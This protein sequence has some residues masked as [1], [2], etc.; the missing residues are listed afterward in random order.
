MFRAGFNATLCILL[1]GCA[2]ADQVASEARDVTVLSRSQ[3]LKAA[4]C[5]ALGRRAEVASGTGS[6]SLSARAAERAIENDA[7]MMG[8]NT[9]VV[10]STND[11]YAGTRIVA[12]IYDCAR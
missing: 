7:V 5:R 2:P 1:A 11:A 8:G 10:V 3:D 9:V 12:D 6:P 4:E